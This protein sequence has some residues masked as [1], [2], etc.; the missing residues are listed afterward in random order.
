MD[1]ILAI[2]MGSLVLNMGLLA[3]LIWK[4]QNLNV[5]ELNIWD[6]RGLIPVKLKPGQVSHVWERPDGIKVA[7][8][9]SEEWGIPKGRRGMVWIG[10]GLTGQ[11]L[12]W[13]MERK[14]WEPK[15]VDANGQPVPGKFLAVEFNAKPVFPDGRW[16]ANAIEDTRERKWWTEQKAAESA[17]GVG[18]KA[19][20]IGG[21]VLVFVFFILPKLT[22]GG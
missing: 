11:F 16:H 21:A 22:G 13:N 17:A 19:L 20:L 3:F 8:E 18:K 1:K 9:C 15:P 2:A 12:R 14:E 5:R 10:H 7:F 6:G 4:K